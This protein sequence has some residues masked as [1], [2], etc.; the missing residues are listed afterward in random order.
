MK[1]LEQHQLDFLA[2]PVSET[3]LPHYARDPLNI[4]IQKKVTHVFQFLFHDDK[5]LLGFERFGQKSLDAVKS[6][7]ASRGLNLDVLREELGWVGQKPDE[8][9]LK[10]IMQ[11]SLSDSVFSMDYSD[12]AHNKILE[13][14]SRYV[15]DITIAFLGKDRT[16]QLGSDAIEDFISERLSKQKSQKRFSNVE[17]GIMGA[18]KDKGW[19]PEFN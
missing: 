16:Q 6:T 18:L 4:Y 1:T 8:S 9:C 7:F 11:K 5:Y 14:R 10:T 3:T 13:A 2:K 12:E 17:S 19:I 15:R